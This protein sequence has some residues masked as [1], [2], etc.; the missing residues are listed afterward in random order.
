M[1]RYRPNQFGLHDMHGNVREWV[2]DCWNDRYRGALA[3][4]TA[5]ESGDC[6]QRVLRG[7]FWINYSGYLRSA[8]RSVSPTALRNLSLGFRVARTVTP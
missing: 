3:D 5:W 8:D 7:G 2:Q 1:G 6:S 4:R